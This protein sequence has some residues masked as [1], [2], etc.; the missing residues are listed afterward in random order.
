MQI[1]NGEISKTFAAVIK[2]RL[3]TLL[4]DDDD[5]TAM[6]DDLYNKLKNILHRPTTAEQDIGYKQFNE[7]TGLSNEVKELCARRRKAKLLLLNYPNNVEIINNY[8]TLNKRVKLDVNKQ[9]SDNLDEKYQKWKKTSKIIIATT[10]LNN[11]RIRRK[12]VQN[13]ILYEK[14]SRVANDEE[15]RYFKYLEITL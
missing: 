4:D 11:Q 2:E 14:V 7:V 13:C 1:Q 15:I 10:N 9:K 8:I 5:D 6:P 3:A 12:K